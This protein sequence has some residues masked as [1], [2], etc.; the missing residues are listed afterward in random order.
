MFKIN[1]MVM[2]G[3]TGVCKVKDIGTPD[4]FDEDEERVYYFLEPVYQNGIIYAPVDNDKVAIRPVISAEEANELL[5]SIDEINAE[6]YKGNSMKQLSQHYQKIIDT[7]NCGALLKL[8][9]SIYAKRMDAIKSKKRLGQIDKRFMKKAEELLYGEFAAA[10]DV[11]KEKVEEY[12]H[13][14][15]NVVLEEDEL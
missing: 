4:F 5:E 7:H 9:K 2:Y 15:L 8:T 6:I 10:L 1:E 3:G 11:D 13:E 12:V 14:K